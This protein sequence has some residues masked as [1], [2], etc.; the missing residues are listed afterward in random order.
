MVYAKKVIYIKI[1]SLK[2]KAYT[3]KFCIIGFSN[4]ILHNFFFYYMEKLIFI[5]SKSCFKKFVQEINITLYSRK[6]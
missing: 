5:H 1:I 3:N 6:F 4:G 2:K